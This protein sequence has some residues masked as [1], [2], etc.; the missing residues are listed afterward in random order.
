MTK[1]NKHKIMDKKRLESI[2]Y[3]KNN[4]IE[5]QVY[6]KSIKKILKKQ[7]LSEFEINILIKKCRDFYRLLNELEENLKSRIYLLKEE[8]PKFETC[9]SKIESN[10]IKILLSKISG[11]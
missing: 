5:I 9:C 6:K 3:H 10:Y 2:K 1:N 4:V 11:S 7:F 8:D